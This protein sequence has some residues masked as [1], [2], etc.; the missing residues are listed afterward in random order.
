MNSWLWK[1]IQR[2]MDPHT[3]SKFRCLRYLAVAK[4]ETVFRNVLSQHSQRA[5]STL[6]YFMLQSQTF[7]N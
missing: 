6:L 5:G 4:R 3:T 1:L 7:N 2:M